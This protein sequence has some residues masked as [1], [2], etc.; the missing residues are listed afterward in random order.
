MNV[1]D[2]WLPILIAGV[3]VHIASTL[4]WTLLP[5]HKPEWLRLPMGPLDDAIPAAGA[6]VGK[7]YILTPTGSDSN[8]PGTDC[9]GTLVLNK[10]SPSMGENIALTISYFVFMSA[11]IGY[12]ASIAMTV[13]TPKLDVFRFTATAAL[14]AYSLGG[15]SHVIWFRRRILL[16]MIDGLVYSLI[17]GGVFAALW[18]ALEV[19]TN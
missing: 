19:A 17:S 7:Q 5:H 14:M 11:V 2:L 18:P 15:L 8:N 6:E 3:A 12:L 1:L 16:D 9:L 4:A 10:R 13:E